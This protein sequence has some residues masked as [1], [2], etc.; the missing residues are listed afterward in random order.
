MATIRPGH[1]HDTEWLDHDTAGLSAGLAATLE[2]EWPGQGQLRYKF[3]SW[4]GGGL[5]GHDTAS[6]LASGGPQYKIL[7][8]G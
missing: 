2:R 7:C 5:L 4:L 1:A 3:V 8:H 6:G